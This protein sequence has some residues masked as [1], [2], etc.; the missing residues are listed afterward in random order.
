MVARER[1]TSLLR[2]V[3]RRFE[4]YP[5]HLEAAMPLFYFSV[6]TLIRHIILVNHTDGLKIIE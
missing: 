2:A 4:S 6:V 5:I 3:Y 1:G